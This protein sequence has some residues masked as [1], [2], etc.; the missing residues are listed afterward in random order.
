M[1]WFMRR[2]QEIDQASLEGVVQGNSAFALALY[3][4]LRV[5]DGNLFYS[6][7]SISTALAMTYAGAR[8]DTQTQMANAMHFS[9]NQDQLHSAFALLR[10]K[11]EASVAGGQI[12]LNVANSLWPGKGYRLLKAFLSLAQKSYEVKITPVDFNEE[13]AARNT[14]NDWVEERTQHRIKDLIA[15]DVL[16]AATRLVL[17]NAIYF[18]GDWAFPFDGSLTTQ[19]PF[20]LA[21]PGGTVQMPMMRRMH[22]F[23]YAE[24]EGLQMLE[25]PYAGQELSMLVLLPREIKGLTGLEGSLDNENLAKWIGS[26]AATEVEVS[27]P[28]F[29]LAFPFRLDE[30]LK[31]MGMK[32][33]FSSQADFSGMD[34]SRELYLG[35]VLHKAFV[36]VNEQGTEAA[37]ATA[38]IMTQKAVSISANIFR[39]DHP[40]IFLIREK[41]TGSI[42]FIGRVAN[43]IQAVLPA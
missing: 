22:S 34:G 38:A 1:Q 30:A 31:S 20:F 2:K 35:A 5:S 16:D 42:L 19:A 43:P 7:F 40:F 15:P 33:A 12:Q 14:I 18:K 39:A 13:E 10:Q 23:R 28:R 21:D 4:K 32:D 11:L 8:T 41:L 26:L 25:L 9:A 3:Q 37:A 6:P 24:D 27:L 36:A 29:E 17:V